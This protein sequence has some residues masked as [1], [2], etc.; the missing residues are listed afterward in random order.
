MCLGSGVYH[1][2]K[3]ITDSPTQENILQIKINIW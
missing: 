1:I 3:N 2:L